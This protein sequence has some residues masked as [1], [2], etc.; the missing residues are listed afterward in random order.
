MTRSCK[1]LFFLSLGTWAVFSIYSFFFS[2]L[3]IIYLLSCWNTMTWL[4][5]SWSTWFL[6]LFHNIVSLTFWVLSLTDN[7]TWDLLF[8]CWDT[9]DTRA[10]FLLAWRSE[11]CHTHKDGD[12]SPKSLIFQIIF[13]FKSFL[14]ILTLV[15]DGYEMLNTLFSFPA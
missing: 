1:H 9:G 6:Q 7:S 5:A 10:V 15:W 12:V 11:L 2:F 4:G 14:F 8:F 13:I 3:R